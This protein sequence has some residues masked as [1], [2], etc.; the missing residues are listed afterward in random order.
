M[1][2][3]GT[4]QARQEFVGGL[5][6]GVTH[7][8]VNA[9]PI[10]LLSESDGKTVVVARDFN[11]TLFV[12]RNYKQVALDRMNQLNGASFEDAWTAFHQ[13]YSSVGIELVPS[14]V[15][16]PDPKVSIVEAP[17]VV[18]SEYIDGTELSLA[19]TKAKVQVAEAMGAMLKTPG[20]Y[21]PSLE[22]IRRDMF[23]VGRNID[24]TPRVV[25]VDVDPFLV[26]R[27]AVESTPD[28]RD[29]W[30]SEYI[31]QVRDLLWDRWCK[32][33]ER[34][35]VLTAFARPLGFVLNTFGQR[36]GERT[37]RAFMNVQSMAKGIDMR[38]FS[39]LPF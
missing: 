21:Y 20:E 34:A 15:I 9:R 39:S 23:R 26:D 33:D 24:R 2:E 31:V 38:K 19:P 27:K 3:A 25:L 7:R 36:D 16:R 22:S 5:E 32:E 18:A 37:L 29:N 10:T 17:V 13:L 4:S 30:F 6:A 12:R 1:I 8:V 14:V 11:K 35:T 28:E